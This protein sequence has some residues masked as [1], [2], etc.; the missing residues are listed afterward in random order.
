[1]RTRYLITRLCPTTGAVSATNACA[2]PASTA[3]SQAAARGEVNAVSGRPEVVVA[4]PYYRII[5]RSVGARGTVSFTETI[6]H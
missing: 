5:V 6:I 1:V 3:I 4:A 2:K